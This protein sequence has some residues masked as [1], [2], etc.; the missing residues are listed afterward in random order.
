MIALENEGIKVS[1]EETLDVFIVMFDKSFGK[2][3]LKLCNELRKLNISC[4]L[5]YLDRNL[6]SQMKY[7]NKINVKN[8]IVI[9]EDEI[10]NNYLNIKNMSTGETV[11]T[12]LDAKSIKEALEIKR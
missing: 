9:G 5:D 8:V 11:K 7:A 2:D 10:S 1:E 3:A 12:E 6:K 4:Y